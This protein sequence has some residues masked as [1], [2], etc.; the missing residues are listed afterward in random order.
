MIVI[1][2]QKKPLYTFK[3]CLIS[4]EEENASDEA[5]SGSRFVST[6]SDKMLVLTILKNR[7]LRL[8]ASKKKRWPSKH[9]L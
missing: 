1:F 5:R 2:D 8:F 4:V 9:S 3:G 6:P 7:D